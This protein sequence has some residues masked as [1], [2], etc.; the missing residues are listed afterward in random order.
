MT[1]I[2]KNRRS[3]ENSEKKNIEIL[4]IFSA[5][6]LFSFGEIQMFQRLE[7]NEIFKFSLLFAYSLIMFVLVI[8]LI[9]RDYSVSG[10]LKLPTMHYV[11]IGLIGLATIVIFF[12]IF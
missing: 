6:V 5:I 8:W 12:N 1:I 10:K 9:T 7:G 11:L 3:I 4:S 2:E